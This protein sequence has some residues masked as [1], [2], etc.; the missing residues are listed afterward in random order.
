MTRSMGYGGNDVLSGGANNDILF[1][2]DGND[3]LDGD[4]G[5]DTLYGQ[6]GNDDLDG[7]A[8]NDIL[9][10]GGGDDTVNGGDNDDIIYGDGAISSRA[11]IDAILNAN[12]G[13]VYNED[14]GNFYQLVTTNANYA[15]ASANA[16]ATTING[17]AGYIVT[18]TSAVE[19]TFIDNLIVASTWIGASDAGVE[20]TWDWIEGPEN[21]TTFW[22]GTGSGSGGAPVGGNYSNWNGAGEPN[23]FG[24]GEDFA[25]IRTNGVWNDVTGTGSRDYVIEWSGSDLLSSSSV[26]DPAG[27]DIINGGDGDDTI[28]GDYIVT[29]SGTQTGWFY[30]Y[31]DLSVTPSTLADAG[32]T[33]NGGKD[34]TNTVDDSGL[35]TDTNP[36]NFDGGSN[37]ALKFTTTL[38]IT[39]GGT[40]TFRTTSDDGS[41]LFLDGVQIVDNDGLHGAVTVTSAGQVLTAGTYTLEATFF[42]RGGG[43]V[44]DIEMS[45][46]DTGSVFVNLENYAGVSVDNV[47][48]PTH[49]DDSISGGDGLDTLYGGGGADSFIFEAA[50]AFLDTDVI[51]DFSTVDGDSIDL[52]DIITGFSGT[53]TD[54]VQFVD[55]AGD[56]LVQ[57]DAN[58]LTGGT[59]FL[60][61]ARIDGLTGLDETTLFNDGNIVV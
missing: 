5:A 40:Y 46:A 3:D 1:G 48:D 51:M 44:M 52:S 10:A 7:G 18:I 27:D 25:E 24:S 28:Y 30:E 17:V 54:Y 31:F 33:L 20:G 37:Y 34:N 12:P 58:G 19:N 42:E 6:D 35:T 15:T 4:S 8:G 23:D 21:G 49:G 9:D 55:S 11:E 22:S 53:I 50:S 14:T 36:V 26:S 13:V 32:F 38:T 56:T 60:T 61:V 57:V 43:E 41:M 2:G 45:G 29:G 59:S 39:T 47:G 16:A